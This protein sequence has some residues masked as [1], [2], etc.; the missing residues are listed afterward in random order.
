MVNLKGYQYFHLKKSL[1]PPFYNHPVAVLPVVIDFPL[2][3]NLASSSGSTS[4][5]GRLGLFPPDFGLL[6]GVAGFFG[7]G[8][9]LEP[10]LIVS[11]SDFESGLIFSGSDFKLTFPSVTGDFSVCIFEV[12]SVFLEVDGRGGFDCGGISTVSGKGN[13]NPR[14]EFYSFSTYE[15][16][17]YTNLNVAVAT[18][19]QICFGFL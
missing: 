13:R 7:E 18:K 17:N 11:G 15:K 3:S 8:S 5:I 4:T 9:D 10:G 2:A 19:I 16:R 6:E 14:V 1:F 12:D